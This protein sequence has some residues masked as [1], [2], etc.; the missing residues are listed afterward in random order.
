MMSDIAEENA[1]FE[2]VEETAFDR[3]Q[4]SVYGRHQES[5]VAR[6]NRNG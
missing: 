6:E 1:D 3:N 5:S 2:L 4:R